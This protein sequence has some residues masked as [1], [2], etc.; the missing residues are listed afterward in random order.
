MIR[1]HGCAPGCNLVFVNHAGQQ[2][3][4]PC[5]PGHKIQR[6]GMLVQADTQLTCSSWCREATGMHLRRA[7]QVSDIKRINGLL[8]DSAMYARGTLLIPKESLHLGY[9]RRVVWM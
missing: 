7:P 6:I 2:A 3:G 9:V 5:R 1:C 4:H 8:T